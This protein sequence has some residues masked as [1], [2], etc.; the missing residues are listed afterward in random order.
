[1]DYKEL[2]NEI[3][4]NQDK[5]LEKVKQQ[6]KEIKEKGQTT[7]KTVNELKALEKNFEQ[8][9]NEL[10]EA[11]AKMNRPG[12]KGFD[13]ME[14][15]T[16][17]EVFAE[18]DAVKHM[19]QN[20]GRDSQPVRFK[21]LF[22]EY[23]AKDLSSA[24]DS[25]G[26]LVVPHRKPGVVQPGQE[27][28]R[29]RDLL[30]VAATSSNAIEYVVES[31]FTNNAG[32]QP[33]EGELKN[34]SDLAFDLETTSVKTIAHW[35]PASRQILSDAP[36]LQ[37]YVNNRLIY[38]LAVKEEEQILYGDGLNG[39]LAGI[40]THAN[41]QDH[42]NRVAED[43]YIDHIRK[44]FT[45]VRLAHYPATGLVLNPVDWEQ[46][47]L[48]KGDDG[49]YIW[50]SVGEGN[51]QRLFRVPVVETTAI[52]E[53]EFLTGAFGLGA[54]LWD[55]EDA[56]VRFSEHHADYFTR[57]MVAILAEERVALEISRPEAFVKGSFEVTAEQ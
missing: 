46:I 18:S 6:E 25:A 50:L 22:Q 26:V 5:I 12:I 3:K 54:Q 42:G 41:I 11:V 36:Q 52:Q 57:N 33:A 38:G 7:D 55:R 13:G 14:K 35:I 23:L 1:M 44:A 24:T 40:M 31:G 29:I 28:L 4:S 53:G 43:N 48:A 56:T 19:I 34:Q 8:L 49:H 32:A 2:L 45:K 37:S 20:G 10:N 16:H 27:Q 51:A 39:N 9:Q 17:G 15:K 47:E 21:S 30:N